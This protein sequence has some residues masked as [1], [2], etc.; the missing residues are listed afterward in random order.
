MSKISKTKA[1]SLILGSKGRF[2][3][4][5][6]IGANNK[7]RTMNCQLRLSGNKTPDVTKIGMV[8]VWEPAS[9]SYKTINLQRLTGLKTGGNTYSV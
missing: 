6:V 1:A 9:K 4:A 8:R 2:F 3:T 7:P 5:T